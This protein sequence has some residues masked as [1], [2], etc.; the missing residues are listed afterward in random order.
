MNDEMANR[1]AQGVIS[2]VILTVIISL[3]FYFLKRGEKKKGRDTE[4]PTTNNSGLLQSYFFQ[5]V[6]NKGVRRLIILGSLLL[7]LLTSLGIWYDEKDSGES[8]R[9]YHIVP[10]IV[11]FTILFVVYWVIYLIVIWIYKGFEESRKQKP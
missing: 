3:I 11:L 7:P 6:S 8:F 4:A 5:V 10:F 2:G 1:I 9:Y